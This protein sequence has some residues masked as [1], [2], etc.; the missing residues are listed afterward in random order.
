MRFIVHEL[1]KA[2][3]DKHSIF[4]WL[5]QRSPM[6]AA[7]WL[8]AYDVLVERLKREAASFGEAIEIAT[9]ISTFDR[10]CSRPVEAVSIE[11]CS[12]S[13]ATKYSS[14]G[15]VARGKRRWHPRISSSRLKVS[16]ACRAWRERMVK[17]NAAHQASS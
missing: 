3:S 4:S 16:L 9:A 2:K 13:K 12:L 8:R 6:G 7:S 1:L 11:R 17:R 5:N 10:H 14:C 15:F